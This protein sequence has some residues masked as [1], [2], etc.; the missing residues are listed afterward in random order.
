VHPNCAS[1]TKASPLWATCKALS[2]ALKTIATMLGGRFF[3]IRQNN[4]P[5]KGGPV[6]EPWPGPNNGI[7]TL[8]LYVQVE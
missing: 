2:P 5:Q 1:S 7:S 4:T 8:L 6:V 3:T